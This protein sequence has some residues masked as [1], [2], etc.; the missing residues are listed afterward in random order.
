MPMPLPDQTRRT[1]LF[2]LALGAIM[3]ST[4]GA[5]PFV[6][7]TDML[8]AQR[9]AVD[10]DA[11]VP[12][13]FGDWHEDRALASAVVN[14]QTEAALRRIYA[15]TLSRIYVN[16]NG[17]RIMLSIAYGSDQGGESTQAHRPEICYAAQGFSLH[18]NHVD[19]L[20]TVHGVIPVRRLVA[21]NGMRHEPLTYWVTV[22]DKATLPGLR[23]K[24]AQLAYGLN[25][26]IPD[27]LIFR[28]SSIQN[29][30]QGAYRLQNGFVDAL[31]DALTPEQR[32]RLAGRTEAGGQA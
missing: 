3:V 17:E 27:G 2:G 11:L 28:V 13:S 14:P 10:L 6:T 20:Q 16:R 32:V 8:A 15:T 24:L 29:D 30:V 5:I 7:P 12:T 25:G 26:T 21:I 31:F 23:R 19:A 22:G 4:A 18:D 1:M 9:P